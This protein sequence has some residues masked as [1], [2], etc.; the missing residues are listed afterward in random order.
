MKYITGER[1]SIGDQVFIGSEEGGYSGIIVA[2]IEDGIF[3]DDYP[4]EKWEYLK[5]GILILTKEAGL[6][7][8]SVADDE[9]KYIRSQ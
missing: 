2:V 6:L 9:V 8:H 7:H 4:R 3:T 5:K 1:I